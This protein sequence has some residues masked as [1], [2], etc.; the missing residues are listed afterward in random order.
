V[1]IAVPGATGECV[2][3]V[4]VTDVPDCHVAV[5]RGD[6]VDPLCDLEVLGA[7]QSR[8]KQPPGAAIT[9]AS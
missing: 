1:T 2:G 9:G 4:E 7:E 3:Q 6:D 5:D 8:A